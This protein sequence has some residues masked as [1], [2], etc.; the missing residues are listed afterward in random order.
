MRRG[1]QKGFLSSRIWLPVDKLQPALNVPLC[2]LLQAVTAFAK[3][4]RSFVNLA[5]GS[6]KVHSPGRVT[7]EPAHDGTYR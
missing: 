7:F 2:S 6:A 4:L 5:A 3:I 1:N